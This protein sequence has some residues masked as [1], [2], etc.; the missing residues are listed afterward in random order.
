MHGAAGYAEFGRGEREAER[1]GALPWALPLLR[2]RV[3]RPGRA[4]DVALRVRQLC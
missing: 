1:A 2:V 3:L 4:P